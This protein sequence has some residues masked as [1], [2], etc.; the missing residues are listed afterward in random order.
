MICI[1]DY[2]L[3]DIECEKPCQVCRQILPTRLILNWM[4]IFEEF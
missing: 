3:I 2:F 4:A 1:T